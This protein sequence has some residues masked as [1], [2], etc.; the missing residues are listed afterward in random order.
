MMKKD[1]DGNEDNAEEKTARSPTD[2]VYKTYKKENE[3][4]WNEI[5]FEQQKK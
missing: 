2:D 5:I 4:S 1:D 3:Y